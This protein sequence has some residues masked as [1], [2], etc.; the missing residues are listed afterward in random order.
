MAQLD[1]WSDMMALERR[2]DEFVRELLGPRARMTFTPLPGGL[3]KPFI[4]STD[5][6]AH[7]GETVIRLDLPG[8]D[9]EKDL[10]VTISDEE[11]VVSGKRVHKQEVEEDDYYRMEATYGAFERRFPVGEKVREADVHATY[12]DGV[13]EIVFPTAKVAPTTKARKVPVKILPR[14]SQGTAA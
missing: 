14:K 13:L 8:I 1:I 12:K 5:V 7:D 11:L 3:R 2:F 6:F 4:P 10:D 9:A